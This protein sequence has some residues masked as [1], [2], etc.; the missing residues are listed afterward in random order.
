MATAALNNVGLGGRHVIN[1]SHNAAATGQLVKKD[2]HLVRVERKSGGTT[3]GNTLSAIGNAGE[4]ALKTGECG[5]GWTGYLTGV[6]GGDPTEA[7]S[8]GKSLN[9]GAKAYGLAGAIAATGNMVNA[10]GRVVSAIEKGLSGK[11]GAA[12]DGT[13]AGVEFLGHGAKGVAQAGEF[14]EF[15][16]KEG[17]VDCANSTL[18]ATIQG[19]K[20]IKDVV[21]LTNGCID[22][23]KT[24]ERHN[25]L[26][27][28]KAAGETIPAQEQEIHDLKGHESWLT[29]VKN[30]AALVL[31]VLSFVGVVLGLVFAQPIL[32]SIGTVVLVTSIALFFIGDNRKALEQEDTIAQIN[33]ELARI[34]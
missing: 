8:I 12:Y 15:L 14:L 18:G 11:S 1:D 34:V 33:D 16:G 22:A 3:L 13:M 19:A 6:L 24:V 2:G 21:D 29:I 10:G 23:A 20:S 17:I 7:V 32:L 30:V 4:L 5:A 9:K 25:K 28:R 26:E 27:A 31:H